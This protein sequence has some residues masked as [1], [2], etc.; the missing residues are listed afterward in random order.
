MLFVELHEQPVTKINLRMDS[1]MSYIEY[2][3]HL[4][5]PVDTN[6]YTGVLISP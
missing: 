6:E 5:L 3:G 2:C 4:I 1:A